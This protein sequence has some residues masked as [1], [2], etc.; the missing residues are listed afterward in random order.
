MSYFG[1]FQCFVC[2]KD[3]NESWNMKIKMIVCV[4]NKKDF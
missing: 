4:R 3:T 2:F 1:N